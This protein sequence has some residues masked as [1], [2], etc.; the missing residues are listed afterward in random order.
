LTYL[1]NNQ[2]FTDESS[3]VQRYRIVERATGDAGRDKLEAFVA[4]RFREAHAACVRHFMPTLVGLEDRK[5]EVRGALGYRSAAQEPLFLEQYLDQPIEE[6]I[7]LRSDS[8]N[9]VARSEIA[10]VG[11]LAG[12]GCRAAMHLVAQIPAYLM[13]RGFRWIAFT[14]TDRVREILRGFDAPVID[15]GPA[16]R[17]RLTTGADDW[18]RYYEAAPRVLVGWLPDGLAFSR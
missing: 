6:L 16:A 11:N 12:R 8:T 3:P 15:L 9:P 7:R 18:G 1:S 2:T 10:E 17:A 5:G 13:N 14:S 4:L